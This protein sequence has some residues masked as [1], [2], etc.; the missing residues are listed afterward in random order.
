MD[1]HQYGGAGNV[2][3]DNCYACSVIW[4]DW[5]EL[6]RIITVPGEE[7]FELDGG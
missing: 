5:G 4:L 7:P 2:V 1:T 6:N 3:I